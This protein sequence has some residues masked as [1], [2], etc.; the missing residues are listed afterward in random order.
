MKT[1][2]QYERQINEESNNL[3]DYINESIIDEGFLSSL[4]ELIKGGLSLYGKM[5]KYSKNAGKEVHNFFKERAKSKADDKTLKSFVAGR[6]FWDNWMAKSKWEK[7]WLEINPKETDKKESLIGNDE[8]VLEEETQQP[9]NQK[10][11]KTNEADFALFSKEKYEQYAKYEGMVDIIIAGFTFVYDLAKSKNDKKALELVSG[12]IKNAL[13]EKSVSEEQKK[14]LKEAIGDVQKASKE[15]KEGEDEEN[16]EVSQEEAQA[17][18]KTLK[19]VQQ[20]IGIKS[21]GVENIV[22]AMFPEGASEETKDFVFESSKAKLPDYA[23]KKGNP[24]VF[25]FRQKYLKGKNND[26]DDKKK[27]IEQNKTAFIIFLN[28]IGGMFDTIQ[29]DKGEITTFIRELVA[30]DEFMG[31]FNK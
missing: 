28:G 1:L 20:K 11:A 4:K 15:K 12:Y 8:V 31:N 24:K 29:A 23:S 27:E 9:N 14:H 16:V 26:A 30:N 19:T 22:K 13:K 3:E 18:E 21:K 25:A 6:E 5:F 10:P 2:K 17:Q 7:P